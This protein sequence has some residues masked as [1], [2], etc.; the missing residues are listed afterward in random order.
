LACAI[1]SLTKWAACTLRSSGPSLS[2][3]T[4]GGCS[5]GGGRLSVRGRR[6]VLG[7]IFIR[8][9]FFR[10]RG[11][12]GSR[13][14]LR[15]CDRLLDGFER[16]YLHA[17][18]NRG[19]SLRGEIEFLCAGLKPELRHF[20]AIVSRWQ[21]GKIEVTVFVCP[22]HPGVTSSCFDQT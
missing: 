3:P 7:R 12:V 18:S 17:Y 8:R 20:C 15:R 2:L 4:P 1:G 19:G 11:G 9:I 5:R 21:S 14:R 13:G 22:A 10:R 6:R 16:C